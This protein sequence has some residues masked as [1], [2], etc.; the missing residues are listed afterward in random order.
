MPLDQAP[1]SEDIKNDQFNRIREYILKH[2]NP[3]IL[4]RMDKGGSIAEAEL[5]AILNDLPEIKKVGKISVPIAN[6]GDDILIYEIEG[7]DFE[8]SRGE[9]L[10]YV[11]VSSGDGKILHHKDDGTSYSIPDSQRSYIT[12]ANGFSTSRLKEMKFVAIGYCGSEKNIENEER[13]SLEEV[14]KELGGRFRNIYR[15]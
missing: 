10:D 14:E 13:R 15:G 8:K 1:S 7:N 3:G 12:D 2:G 9:N 5:I 11:N 6:Y 4:E